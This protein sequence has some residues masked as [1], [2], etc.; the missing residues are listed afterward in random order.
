V[1]AFCVF[2][3]LTRTISSFYQLCHDVMPKPDLISSLTFY[4]NEFLFPASYAS[5][6]CQLPSASS[7]LSH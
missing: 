2:E 3:L 5:A 6:N 1:V 7:R 4:E